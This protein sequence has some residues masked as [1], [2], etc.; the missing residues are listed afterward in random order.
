ME[1]FTL[2]ANFLA[3]LA[4]HGLMQLSSEIERLDTAICN[5]VANL[6]MMFVPPI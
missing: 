3:G 5:V 4:G 1:T 2:I 6:L